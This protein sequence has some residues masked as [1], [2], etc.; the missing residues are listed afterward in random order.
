[1][2]RKRR[3]H[4]RKGFR[5]IRSGKT[6][7]Q[8]DRIAKK[9]LRKDVRKMTESTKVPD[10]IIKEQ[11]QTTNVVKAAK[12][13][14]TDQLLKGMDAVKD[15]AKRRAAKMYLIA[16][17]VRQLFIPGGVTTTPIKGE[18]TDENVFIKLAFSQGTYTDQFGITREHRWQIEIYSR[19][20]VPE[21]ICPRCDGEM[22][23]EI[24]DDG[25][26]RVACNDCGHEHSSVW[27]VE[28]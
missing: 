12:S 7:R 4:N 23:T 8:V 10:D 20:H 15:I 26:I 1:M 13:P 18:L 24:L 19:D 28:A 25:K 21:G 3:H 16:E 14:Q 6:A 17:K 11:Q 5:A 22:E 9:I 27:G 2:K